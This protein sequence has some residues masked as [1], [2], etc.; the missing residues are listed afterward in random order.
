MINET[1]AQLLS[2]INKDELVGLTQDLIRIDS[3]IRPETGNTEAGVVRFIAD[4]IQRE[5][6]VKP[7]IQ[8]VVPLRENIIVTI[9]SGKPGPCLMFEGHTDVVSEGN[10]AL[11]HHDPFGGEI[12]DGKIYGRGSCDMKAGLAVNLLTVKAMMKSKVDFKGKMRLGIV[13]DEED[14]MLGIQD[15]IK[16]GHADDVDACL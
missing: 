3:V 5:L 10:R 11:W 12:H 2:F 14:L 16:K 1:E 7:L 6:G 9:D 4:W 8:E 15:F 13:C